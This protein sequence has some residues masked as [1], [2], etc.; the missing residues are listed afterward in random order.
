MEKDKGG[1][2]DFHKNGFWQ[3]GKSKG[4]GKY[5]GDG[6]N[7]GKGKGKD[8]KSK[9]KGK[10]EERHCHVCGKQG[11]LA[12]D[13]YSRSAVRQVQETKPAAPSNST[14][15]SSFAA[16]P[17]TLPSSSTSGAASSSQLV[18][19]VEENDHIQART[20][21]FDMQSAENSFSLSPKHVRVVSSECEHFFIGDD[22]DGLFAEFEQ[23]DERDLRQ[24]IGST[25]LTMATSHS[26]INMD[27]YEGIEVG[28]SF[29]IG[30]G[31]WQP[32]SLRRSTCCYVV[33]YVV[34][35]VQFFLVEYVNILV[36][37]FMLEESE[38]RL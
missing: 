30:D 35:L 18:R 13:C 15:S 2:K 32:T 31:D 21:C 6:G 11:H 9:G 4:K 16:P 23:L 1:G 34:V 38:K 25:C 36:E 26:S 5:K 37:I 20:L 3:D 14:T 22:S 24:E 17:G 29:K 28:P 33:K 7:K 10:R 12:K 19:K 27:E 8:G